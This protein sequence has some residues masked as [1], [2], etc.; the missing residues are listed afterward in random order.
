MG[1]RRIHHSSKK[2]SEEQKI[3]MDASLGVAEWQ[4]DETMQQ[5]IER[6][7]VIM[8]EVKALASKEPKPSPGPA[9]KM[10]RIIS[11]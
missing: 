10:E 7:D 5:L 3:R 4:S 6:A 8:Y 2:S 11:L 1:V 9:K